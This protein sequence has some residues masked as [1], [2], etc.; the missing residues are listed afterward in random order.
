M[1]DS[2]AGAVFER[3]RLIEERHIDA[4][5]HVNNIV[6]VRFVVEL[7][8]A[9]AAHVGWDEAA[10]RDAGAWWVVHRQELIYHRPAFAGERILERTRIAEMRGA[11]CERESFF[12]RS[13]EVLVEARTTWVWTDAS[14][15]RPRRVPAEVA[16]AFGVSSRRSRK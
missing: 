12:H 6:W 4:L 11:R 3:E 14:A 16:L 1:T 9:H 2:A 15:G 10:L 13:G 8:S 7:A 5:G